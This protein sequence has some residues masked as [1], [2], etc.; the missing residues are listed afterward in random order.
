MTFAHSITYIAFAIGCLLAHA[1]WLQLLAILRRRQGL[2]PALLLNPRERFDLERITIDALQRKI[3]RDP[4]ARERFLSTYLASA[5]NLSDELVRHT[6]QDA[7]HADRFV[8]NSVRRLDDP[9]LIRLSDLLGRLPPDSSLHNRRQSADQLARTWVASQKVVLACGLVICVLM[10]LFPPW[11]AQS[12]RRTHVIDGGQSRQLL[13]R[14]S[15][16]YRWVGN[17]AVPAPRI[18]YRTT[19]DLRRLEQDEFRWVINYRRLAAQCAL[20]MLCSGAA[21]WMLRPAPQQPQ[22]SVRRS[23]RL[24]SR[25]PAWL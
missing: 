19:N 24:P 6:R 13:E 2:A 10:I 22:W 16:G 3:H 23:H 20:L 25:D 12:Q 21:V 15:V 14:T 17:R 7:S 9:A 1:G 4:S 5:A 11:V 18:T 8:A